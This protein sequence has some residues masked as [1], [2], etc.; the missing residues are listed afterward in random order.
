[1]NNTV[2]LQQISRTDNLDSNL[3]LRQQKLDLMARFMEIKSVNLILRQD[4]IAKELGC[5]SNTLQRY[6][7]DIKMLSPYRISSNSKKTKR[8]VPNHDLERPQMTSIDLKWPQNNPL[9]ILKRLNLT[10][11]RKTNWTQEQNWN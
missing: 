3:I 4:Q 8:K 11:L 9:Q 7:N 10:Y 1:M 6:R 2:S 5:S